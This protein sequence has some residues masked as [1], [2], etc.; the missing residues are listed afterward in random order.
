MYVW[1]TGWVVACD[2]LYHGRSGGLVIGEF[3]LD[4]HVT[5]RMGDGEL[6]WLWSRLAL[7]S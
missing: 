2:V 5:R 6:G 7:V 1:V 4:G 3:E